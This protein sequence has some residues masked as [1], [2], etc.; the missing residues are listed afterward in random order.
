M[1]NDDGV[2]FLKNLQA[3]SEIREQ[4]H[5]PHWLE[6]AFYAKGLRFP[7]VEV[8]GELERR[9]TEMSSIDDLPERM[10]PW[11]SSLF[12]TIRSALPVT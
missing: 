2:A 6:K 11:V 9:I 1:A 12:R 10:R 5:L 8:A 4:A 7:K 3:H